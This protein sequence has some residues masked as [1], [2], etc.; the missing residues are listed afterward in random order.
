MKTISLS[1]CSNFC[2]CFCLRPVLTSK[3]C[4]QK[5]MSNLI[6]LGKT[7]VEYK[8]RFHCS[9]NIMCRMTRCYLVVTNFFYFLVLMRTFLLRKR[10]FFAVNF[11]EISAFLNVL[12]HSANFSETSRQRKVY[13]SSKLPKSQIQLEEL[14]P[15]PKESTHT[16][17]FTHT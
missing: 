2:Q 7:T 10:C 5:A 4:C 11:P 13:S 1:S 6:I 8:W 9:A 16:H 14:V 17:T 15:T 3:K 12:N